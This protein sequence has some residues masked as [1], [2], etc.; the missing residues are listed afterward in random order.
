MKL[1]TM[2]KLLPTDTQRQLLYQTLATANAAC[3]TISSVAWQTKRFGRSAVH[4]LTYDTLRLQYPLASQVVIRC[5][6]KVVDAYKKDSKKKRHFKKLGAIAYDDRIL[7][8]RIPDKQVSI[9]LLGGRQS[10]PFVGGEHHELLLQHQQGESDLKYHK[11]NFYLLA[12][13][14]VLAK[15]PVTID[16][17]LGVDVGIVRIATDSD[18]THYA[19]NHLNNV[20]HR[21]RRLR[22]KLQTKQTDS[23]RHKLQKL[24]GREA[25]FA[26][27]INHVISKSIVKTAQGTRR[28]IALEELTH[29]RTR[30]TVNKPQRNTLHSWSFKQL[31][32]FVEYKAQQVGVVVVCVDPRNTSR[33]CSICGHIEKA[34]RRSQSS[35]QCVSCGFSLNADHN[36]ALNIRVRGRALVSAPNVGMV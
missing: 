17:V 13:C 19:G 27:D 21:Y 35:F 18:G 2:V 29:I 8:W 31:R 9:W 15:D 23:A 7:S 5:I 12:T 26:R 30:V 4:R 32:D 11:G 20:R 22:Q 16:D 1:T 36:A 14:D 33:Q 10:I 24:A 25:R 28:G 6:A 3:N 34:N